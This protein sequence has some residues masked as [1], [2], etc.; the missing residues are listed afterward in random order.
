MLLEATRR[1]VASSGMR[2][3]TAADIIDAAGVGRNT[4][5]EH[6]ATSAAAVTEVVR[7]ATEELAAALRDA[8]RA[9][10]TPRERLR[11]LSSTWLSEMSRH[12]VLIAVSFGGSSAERSG[13]LKVLETEL[14]AALELARNAGTVGLVADP[15]RVAC[16][17]GAFLG[18]LEH[19]TAEASVDVRSASEVLTDVALRSF[20]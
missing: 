18:A 2:G 11:A 9:A 16:L 19:V 5:Y 7:G 14:R 3:A 10:R 4:F 8:A 1:V 13:V 20:R 17:T 15:F 12:E 6:F